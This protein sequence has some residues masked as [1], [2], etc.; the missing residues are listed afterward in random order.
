MDAIHN[1]DH[2]ETDQE[3][4]GGTPTFSGR[5]R[6]LFLMALL[7]TVFAFSAFGQ[8]SRDGLERGNKDAVVKIEVYYDLQCGS[9]AAYHSVLKTV[10]KKFGDNVLITFRHFPLHLHDK[11]ILAARAL[12]AAQLQ[13]KGWKMLDLILAGQNQW[14]PNRSAKYVFL[15]YAKRLRLNTR[16][17]RSDLESETVL[18][19]IIDDMFLAKQLK[20][21]STPTVFLNGEQLQ[22]SDALDIETKIQEIVK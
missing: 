9:C 1:S 21:N 2:I 6:A 10:E 3:K 19:R 18:H 16:R 8:N 13:G 4:L 12:E 7:L 5:A 17:F 15:T 20:L 11:A 22:Y 14:S